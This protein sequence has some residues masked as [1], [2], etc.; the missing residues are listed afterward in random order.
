MAGAAGRRLFR[1]GDYELD[2]ACLEL[3]RKGRPVRL[4]RLPMQLLLLL[5]ERRDELVDREAIT[6]RLWGQ[7]I[8]LDADNGINTAIR[9]LRHVF[10]D[11]AGRPRFIKTVTG[12]GYRFIAP[13]EVIERPASQDIPSPR[14]MIAVLPFENLSPAGGQ[15]YLADGITEEAITHLGQL[16]S[17]NL[18]VIARTSTMALKDARKTIGQIGAELNVDF[19]LESSIRRGEARIRITSRL[20][21]VSTQ[22]QVWSGA[23]ERDAEQFLGLQNELGEA[24]ARAVH[25]RLAPQ[26]GR[27]RQYT[28][29][30]DAYDQ[31]LH[32]LF[33]RNQWSPAAIA[34]AIE[35]YRTAVTIDPDYALAWAGLAECHAFLPVNAEAPALEILPVAS[36]AARRA[37]ELAPEMPEAHSSLGAVQLWMEWDWPGAEA[38]LRRA[39]ELNASNADA[40]RW[41]AILLNNLGKFEESAREIA[42]AREL[43]PVSPLTHGLSGALANHARRDSLAAGHLRRA[44]T[45]NPNLWVLH[46]WNGRVLAC[47]GR[48]EDALQELREAVEGSRG[49]CEA[50]ALQSW[51]QARAGNPAAAREVLRELG[52]MGETKYVP[53]TSFAM[54]HAAL[55]END[56]AL[57][58]LDKAYA[59][60]DARLT[61]LAVEPRWDTIREEPRFQDLLDKLRLPRLRFG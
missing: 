39:I 28:K 52:R 20:I 61:W 33:F 17:Q 18:G 57:D 6:A 13:V 47:Q 30:P 14:A 45:L 51:I 1:F 19:V 26:T 11:Q 55:G 50:V 40:R 54:I 60:R 58:W 7:G 29:N 49:S 8:H 42:R 34:Q 46:L 16:D 10:R 48:F 27:E 15:D 25:E 2:P 23:F 35:C 41:R 31:Y 38:S 5:M 9:K 24:I 32:A 44:L 37:V 56:R 36:K 59:S 53:P 21:R 3:S 43:D 22:S 12:A 4:E